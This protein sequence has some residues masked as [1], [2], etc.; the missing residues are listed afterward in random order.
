MSDFMGVVSLWFELVKRE[1]DE[2]L[3]SGVVEVTHEEPFD[4]TMSI[5]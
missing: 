1:I 4:S 2:V 5:L 3:V